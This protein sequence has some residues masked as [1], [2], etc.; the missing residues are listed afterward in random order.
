M[1]SKNSFTPEQVA[2]LADLTVPTILHHIR[3]KRIKAK[4]VRGYKIAA[5][6]VATFLIAQAAVKRKTVNS[7][8]RKDQG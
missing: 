7:Y 1:N 6:D 4:K 8:K 5:A 2:N 3:K